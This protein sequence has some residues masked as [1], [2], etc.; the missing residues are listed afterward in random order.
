MPVP[1]DR[2]HWPRWSLI[3]FYKAIQAVKGVYPLYYEGDERT[4]R[5]DQ[6]FAEV[7]L[8]GPDIDQPSRNQFFLNCTL[9][10]LISHKMSPSDLYLPEKVLGQFEDGFTDTVSVYRYGNGPDDDQSFLG[11]YVLQDPIETNKFGIIDKDYRVVQVTLEA[12]YRMYLEG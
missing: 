12:E 2:K 3:S 10:V 8:D 6:N 4:T 9:N 11:C 1:S 7:R 5:L